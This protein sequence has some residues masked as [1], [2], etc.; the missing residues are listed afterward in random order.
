MP[1]TGRTLAPTPPRLAKL[2][3]PRSALSTDLFPGAASSQRGSR[4]PAHLPVVGLTREVEANARPEAL[5][6]ALPIKALTLDFV[7]TED[8]EDDQEAGRRRDRKSV[9]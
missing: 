3:L 1:A 2:L 5:T 9:V 8:E 4:R 6:S 7:E